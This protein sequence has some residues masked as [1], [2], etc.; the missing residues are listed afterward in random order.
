MRVL[1]TGANGF[2]GPYVGDALRSVCGKDVA[3]VAT[4]KDGGPHPV[5]G[6][7]EELDVTD[8]AAVQDAIARHRPT[9]VIHMAAVAALGAARADPRNAW[10][11]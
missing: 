9:Q 2:V 8:T 10:R 4:S 11:I 1:I 5:F 7:V 6:R 3:I